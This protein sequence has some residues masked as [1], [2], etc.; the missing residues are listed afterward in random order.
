MIPDEISK[1]H[2]IYFT[3]FSR[4]DTED[5]DENRLKNI[6]EKYPDLKLQELS[7]G[8]KCW[9]EFF[10]KGMIDTELLEEGISSSA[11]FINENMPKWSKL[12]HYEY[13]SDDE[14]ETL[15]KLVSKEFETH[16]YTEIGVIIHV[17]GLLLRFSD[18]KLYTKGKDKILKDAKNFIDALI[19]QEKLVYDDRSLALVMNLESYAG[20]GFAGREYEE[21][22]NFNSFLLQKMEEEKIAHMPDSGTELLNIMRQDV[23]KFFRMI[24][25]SNS[26]E[27]IYCD[28]PILQYID[29]GEFVKTSL[30][31][32]PSEIGDSYLA[33]KERYKHDHINKNLIEERHW[34]KEVRKHLKV[35]QRKRKGKLSGDRLKHIIK[36]DLTP[37]I[38][39]LEKM[40]A[41]QKTK[42]EA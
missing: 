13:L 37:N 4:T 32:K 25:F 3:Q 28:K 22:Q 31:L 15:I 19:E 6:M 16:L 14:F 24:C 9:E 29:S 20:L 11:Y 7:L 39:K 12:W 27:Q 40:K 21:F 17:F 42:E 30:S 10:D 26:S 41:S 2:Y 38:E 34:L 23:S 35:E 18:R 33:L 36:D 8:E 5:E 1:L